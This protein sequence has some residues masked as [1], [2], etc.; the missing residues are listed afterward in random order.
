MLREALKEALAQSVVAGNPGSSGGDNASA[1]TS[2][3]QQ[4]Q[5]QQ[6]RHDRQQEQ[7]EVLARP[8]RDR[9]QVARN[10]PQQQGGAVMPYT[11]RTGR[12]VKHVAPVDV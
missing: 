10:A 12:R 5:Q 9:E 4:E 1:D 8:P 11:T 7:V 2:P 3:Q 6:H